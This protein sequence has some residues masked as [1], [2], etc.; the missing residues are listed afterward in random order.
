MSARAGP[1]RGGVPQ[2]LI[3]GV[4]LYNVTTDDLEG[5]EEIEGPLGELSSED[6]SEDSA[7]QCPDLA[8]RGASTPSSTAPPYWLPPDDSP[9]RDRPAAAMGTYLPVGSNAERAARAAVRRIVYS[10][11]EE[12]AIPIEYSRKNVKWKDMEPKL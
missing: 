9:I 2:G 1:I 10:S 12:E 6:D 8:V 7:T 3:L 5:N 11:E 4:F